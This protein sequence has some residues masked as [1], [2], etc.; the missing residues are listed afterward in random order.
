MIDDWISSLREQIV[1]SDRSL[2]KIFEIYAAEAKFG[3]TF[4]DAN[5]DLLRCNASILEIG[6]GAM[7][8]SCQ[9]VREGF[10]VTALEPTSNPFS[11]FSK[12]RSLI[13]KHASISKCLPKIS[14][15]KAEDIFQKE[16]FDFIFSIN[17]MEHVESVE[18]VINSAA[19][20]LK[21]NHSYR[22]TCPNYLF[23]YEPHFN[24][25]TL[26]NKKLTWVLFRGLITNNSKLNKPG[27]L[28]ESLNWISFMSISKVSIKN[29]AIKISYNKNI[30]TDTL[31]RT[32][33]DY[34]FSSRRS[35]HMRLLIR[36]LVF[37]KVHKLLSRFPLLMQ[38]II[39][40]TITRI[41]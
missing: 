2:I 38:P 41:K 6:A 39:D 18:Q 32:L 40:C 36:G 23:P 25:P 37:F 34:E 27:D 4:I 31:V 3:R 11:H 5:L 17:V 22:F 16:K 26:I 7:I 12:M 29:K 28:W 35:A 33:T 9:L 13:L 1:R 10:S 30:L 8:L 20:A 21:I 19:N 15:V 14:L 24:I